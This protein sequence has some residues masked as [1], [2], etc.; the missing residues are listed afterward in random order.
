MVTM[1]T[2]PPVVEY[3][4]VVPTTTE[5]SE[6]LAVPHDS[7]YINTF[8]RLSM[9]LHQQRKVEHLSSGMDASV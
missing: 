5:R 9:V 8:S 2:V 7:T 1:K 4:S 6:K 3:H